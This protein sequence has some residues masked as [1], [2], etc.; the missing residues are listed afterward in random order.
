MSA[1]TR[2]VLGVKHPGPRAT[3]LLK[4]EVSI[5][6]PCCH[7]SSGAQSPQPGGAAGRPQAS[8]SVMRAPSHSLCR[9][10]AGTN[11]SG[12]TPRS[13]SAPGWEAM[14]LRPIGYLLV[15]TKLNSCSTVPRALGSRA[16]VGP[17]G[18]LAPSVYRNPQS[19]HLLSQ[20]FGLSC[21][22]FW[23]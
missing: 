14:D 8:A 3:S 12:D 7:C 22:S 23:R 17:I 11:F 2:A 16:G 5:C 19:F 6:D 4:R 20:F 13:L 18:S 21:K 1:T 10:F 15:R 9:S